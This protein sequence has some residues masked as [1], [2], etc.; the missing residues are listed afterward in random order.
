MASIDLVLSMQVCYERAALETCPLTGIFGQINYTVCREGGA[1]QSNNT[2]TGA[3]D[4]LD[5]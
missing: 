4:V 3:V 5:C 2:M 1:L